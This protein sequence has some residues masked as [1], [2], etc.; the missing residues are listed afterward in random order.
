L[1]AASAPE[2]ASRLR[3]ASSHSLRWSACRTHD[4]AFDLEGVS[5]DLRIGA[6]GQIAEMLT[7]LVRQGLPLPQ[8]QLDPNAV[9]LVPHRAW[10]PVEIGWPGRID[11]CLL[12]QR[13]RR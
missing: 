5:P 11:A 12:T 4:E 7:I 1:A 3:S 8:V 10:N 2:S 9:Q 13:A 6:T